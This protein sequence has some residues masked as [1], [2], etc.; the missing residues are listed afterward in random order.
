MKT[1][2][3]YEVQ[4]NGVRYIRTD[5]YDEA[6]RFA[7]QCATEALKGSGSLNGDWTIPGHD[8][9]ILDRI[10]GMTTKECEL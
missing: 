1:K 3:R 6:K 2:T 9:R 10:T 4:D 8:V 5:D 7:R